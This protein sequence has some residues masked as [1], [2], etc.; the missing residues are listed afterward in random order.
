M[1]KVNF[2]AGPAIMP[3]TVFEQAAQAVLEYNGIGLSLLEISH[4]SHWFTEIMENTIQLVRDL[5]H[6]SS[7]YEVLFLTGG[8]STQFCL[9][10]YNIL[11]ST[12]TAAYLDTGRWSAKAIKEANLFGQV[13]VIASAAD[14][15]YTYVPKTYALKKDYTY[16][17]ITTNNTVHGTQLFDMPD[18]PCPL[19][20]DMSSDIFSKPMNHLEKFG[21]IYAGAQKNM[22]P[23]GTTLVIVRKDLLGKVDRT[24]PTILD[25][26]TH[27]G[28]A[29]VYNT[30]PV[31]PIYCCYLTLQWI[32]KQG[33]AQIEANNQAKA[34]LLYK[35]ID[36]NGLFSGLVNKEDRSIMN[37]VFKTVDKKLEKDFLQLAEMANCIGLK[38]YRTIGGFR[39]SL[40]NA[41]AID[42]VQVLVDAMQ[43]FER[44]FG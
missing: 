1:K 39:A 37:V 3:Q 9:V 13:E 29:S 5:Y 21:V 32:Q 36:R 43:E 17:H 27:I 6:I 4:R 31:F 11:P 34:S 16:L 44:K 30:P 38:G 15:D 18:V 2:C 7:D 26:Q 10:P 20:A 12:G 40:Y 28:K 35:E 23:A 8:A 19:V 14:S 33:L 42:G 22:G 25:Y 24:I 41:L